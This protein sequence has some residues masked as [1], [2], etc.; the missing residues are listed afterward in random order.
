M[1]GAYEGLVKGDVQAVLEMMGFRKR[2]RRQLFSELMEMERAA[3][4]AFSD[5]DDG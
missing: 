4:V 3:L 5:G 1:E 2:R